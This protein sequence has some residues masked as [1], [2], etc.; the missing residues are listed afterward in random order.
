[1][2][3]H[4]FGSVV[5]EVVGVVRQRANMLQEE[6]ASRARQ[7]TVDTRTSYDKQIG[8]TDI[9]QNDAAIMEDDGDDE[10]GEGTD[11][12]SPL[13]G[14][15]GHQGTPVNADAY[16]DLHRFAQQVWVTKLIIIIDVLQIFLRNSESYTWIFL[17]N[18]T[19][20]KYQ[21]ILY[22]DNESGAGGA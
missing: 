15:S 10:D 8:T 7:V 12:V 19:A 20:R 1:M 5:E 9:I 2:L 17:L 16:P 18:T 11:V 14:S 13:L 3:H 4:G 6:V 21:K 22:E